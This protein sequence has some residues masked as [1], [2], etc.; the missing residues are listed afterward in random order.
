MLY[1]LVYRQFSDLDHFD[2]QTLG[3]EQP[4]YEKIDREPWIYPSM[5]VLAHVSLHQHDFENVINCGLKPIET[6]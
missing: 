1:Y 2:H 6:L 4:I 5:G 3:S